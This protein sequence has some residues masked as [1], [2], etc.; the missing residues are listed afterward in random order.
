LGATTVTASFF[1]EEQSVEYRLPFEFKTG[2]AYKFT[3][4]EIEVDLITHL[5]AGVYD[6]V[7]NSRRIIVLTDTGSGAVTVQ[8][9]ETVPRVVDSRAVVNIAIGGHYNLTVD[10]KWVLHG[11]YGT[12]RSP[13]GEADTEFTKV[14][15]QKVTVG[16]SGRT[17]FFL[18]SLGLQYLA[19]S[20]GPVRLRQLQGGHPLT[21]SFKVANLGFV[22][23]LALLF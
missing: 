16:V 18:G 9:F 7:T 6:A 14:H 4:G 23:S 21:T 22:Y 20:S 8:E 10:G 17:R 5:G 13:V 15:L 11:G 19:G 3:R 1:D 2:A 12:D